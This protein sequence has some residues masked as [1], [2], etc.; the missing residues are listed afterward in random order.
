[1]ECLVTYSEG[2]TWPEGVWGEYWGTR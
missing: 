2:V 1:M